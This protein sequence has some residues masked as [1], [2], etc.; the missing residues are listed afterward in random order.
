MNTINEKYKDLQN[1]TEVKELSLINDVNA[2]IKQGW[3]LL[4]TYKTASADQTQSI[5]YCMGWPKSAGK[6]VT[7]INKAK[8]VN[9]KTAKKFVYSL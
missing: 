2:H 1:I 7:S 5:N 3:K 4:N 6:A 9:S 8:P